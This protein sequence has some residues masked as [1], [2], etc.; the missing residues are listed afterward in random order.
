MATTSAQQTHEV[1]TVATWSLRRAAELGR[2]LLKARNINVGQLL[3]DITLA[4]CIMGVVATVACALAA[5][6]GLI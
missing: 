5:L 2:S 1:R 6:V 4:L 3:D